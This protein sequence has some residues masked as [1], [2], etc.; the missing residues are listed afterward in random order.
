MNIKNFER[1]NRDIET[2]VGKYPMRFI[3]YKNIWSQEIR[4]LG[5]VAT[6]LAVLLGSTCTSGTRSGIPV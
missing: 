1:F 3:K 6:G 4:K 5:G 2:L